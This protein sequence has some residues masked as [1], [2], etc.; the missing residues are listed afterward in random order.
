MVIQIINMFVLMFLLNRVLY[1]PVKAILQERSEKLEAMQADISQTE[2]DARTR[3]AEVNAKMAKASSR[4]KEALDSARAAAQTAGDAKL[5]EI[6]KS[7]DDD[8]A[9][10][11]AEI[12]AQM[13]S[14]RKS[15]K[16]NLDGFAAE[17]A[18][19]IL[20]RSLQ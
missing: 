11:L 9:R 14:A 15:L 4:A 1:K 19:K 12:S 17:M 13:E 7:T 20:G 5:A 18:G 16:E 8:K 3:Q 2:M 6:K 10:H